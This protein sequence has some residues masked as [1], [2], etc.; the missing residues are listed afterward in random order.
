MVSEAPGRKPVP[1]TVRDVPPDAP[2]DDGKTPRMANGGGASVVTSWQAENS[3]VIQSFDAVL[4]TTEPGSSDAASTTEK[5][6]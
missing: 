4:V 3:E 2:P 6:A 5:T 1:R